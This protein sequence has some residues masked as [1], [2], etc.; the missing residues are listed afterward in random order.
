M[1][2]RLIAT[3]MDDTLLGPGGELSE[4]TKAAVAEA[5]RRGVLFALASGRMPQ[6]MRETATQLQVNCPAIAYNGGM[7]ADLAG[8]TVVRSWPVPQGLAREAAKIAE[9]LGGHVQA[10]KN[11]TYYFAENN[12]YARAYG[13]SIR[14]YGQEAGEKLSKWFTGDADKLLVIGQPEQISQWVLKMQAHFGERLSCAVSRPNYIEVFRSGVDK[15][16]ALQEL[17][18]SYGLKPDEV[19]AFGDGENDLGMVQ[20]AGH[21]YIMANARP[22][23]LAKAPAIAPSN[24]Q[25]GLAQ[26][27]EQWFENGM[28]PESSSYAQRREAEQ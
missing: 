10:Y 13:D 19:A 26:V 2:I 15:A 21:G 28:I 7:I 11:G 6:A 25:D 5:M 8:G 12:E 16:V 14:L 17:A 3:D 9:E 27:L 22:Q 1:A 24:A 20:W 23:V 18:A 4:R